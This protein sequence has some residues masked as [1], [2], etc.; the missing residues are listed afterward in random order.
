MYLLK[1]G[2]ALAGGLVRFSLFRAWLLLDRYLSMLLSIF[3]SL[4]KLKQT[5][6]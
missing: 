4:A 1:L 6:L 2:E 5:A 3:F